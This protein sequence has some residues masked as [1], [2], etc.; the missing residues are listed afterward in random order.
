MRLEH[1]GQFDPSLP[2]LQLFGQ[3]HNHN[4]IKIPAVVDVNDSFLKI[5]NIGINSPGPARF[6]EGLSDK[7]QVQLIGFG[8]DFICSLIPTAGIIAVLDIGDNEIGGDLVPRI[9]C[10]KLSPPLAIFYDHRGS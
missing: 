1:R 3:V 9:A 6:I 5:A 7:L 8:E 2:F 10:N 4:L